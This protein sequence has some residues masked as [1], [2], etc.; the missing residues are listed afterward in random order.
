MKEIKCNTCITFPKKQFP[1]QCL[2]RYEIDICTSGCPSPQQY[3]SVCVCVCLCML[4]YV[5]S[6]TL[7]VSGQFGQK[8]GRRK[9]RRF[10]VFMSAAVCSLWRRPPCQAGALLNPWNRSSLTLGP[11]N[12]MQ[13]W[14]QASFQGGRAG[15]RG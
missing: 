2:S 9:K 10:K 4:H 13:C 15:G 11:L 1:P 7:S 8:K 3:V 6:S 12:R 14:G 5:D